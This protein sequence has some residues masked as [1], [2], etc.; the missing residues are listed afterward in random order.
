MNQILSHSILRVIFAIPFAVFGIMHLMKAD[1]MQ[2]MVPSYV[3]GGVI[4]VYVIGVLL[5][6]GATGL[7]LNKSAQYAGYLLGGLLLIFILTI[8]L[9]NFLGGDQN[10][11]GS[12]LK[13]ISLMGAAFYIGS[14]SGNK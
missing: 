13:D 12:L 7:I 8:H 3:P 11:M 6:V 5:I 1:Q 10:S 9:P 2:G 4:W 14:S